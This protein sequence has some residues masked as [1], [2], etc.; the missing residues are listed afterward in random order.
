MTPQEL[1]DS[2][3]QLAIQGQLAEQNVSETVT[4]EEGF[5]LEEPL[6]DLPPNWQW[7]TLGKCCTMY[8]GNSISEEE[9]NAKYKGQKAGFD[10]IGTK[11]ISFH[12]TISYD[13]GVRIPFQNDFKRAFSGS[14]LM[15]IEGG[16][17]GRKIAILN[18][19]V[20]FGNKLCMF[21]GITVLN[22]YLF[23]FLQSPAFRKTFLGNLAGIIG[24]V[25]I[26]KLKNILLPVPPKA[27][28]VRIVAKIEELLPLIDRYEQAWNRLEDFNNR[29][30]I[31]MQKSILQWAI[32][33]KLVEQRPE[34][35]TGE[36]LYQLIQA[37]KKRLIKEGKIKREKPLPEIT[38]EEKP[39]DIP[40]SWEWVR[41]C[42]LGI[43]QTGNTPSKTH[44]EYQGNDIPFIT[45]GDILNDDINYGNQSLSIAGMRV[46]RICEAGSILQVCIGGSIGK[47]ALTRK[48]VTFN[49]QINAITPIFCD[50]RYIYY[51]MRSYY[52]IKLM[53]EKAGGTATP[54]IN[55]GIWGTLLISLPPLAEQKRI[56][57][58]LEELLPLCER[59]K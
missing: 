27:E 23:Y 28:Q 53:K 14:I 16:S 46:A 10:Y 32:Q 15:C 57:A 7:Q 35:G 25:S 38:E 6:F 4:S 18:R 59:L 44:L 30:P 42:S 5:L 2:I 37:E 19:D 55:R 50:S 20:C 24:G 26:K 31:D 56:V 43:T 39:F 3:L 11:D 47:V 52:F 51:A 36:E 34:E 8:T 49:Q 21:R 40:E 13:N 41:V 33:G 48:R 45:P 29:F 12:H 9:K 17:A 58:K 1:R 22:K 54:I